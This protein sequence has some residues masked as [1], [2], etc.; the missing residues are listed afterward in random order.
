VADQEKLRLFTAIRIPSG[1]L[2]AIDAE[3]APHR[4]AF[5][6]ARWAPVENQ[7][8]TLKFLGSTPAPKVPDVKEAL[9]GVAAD[10]APGRI[11]LTS[12]GAF[13]TPRRARVLWIGVDDPAGLLTGLAYGL[14]R[15]LA[16]LGFKVEE[17]TYHPHLTLAR[18]KVPRALPE[19]LPDAAAGLAPF[20]VDEMVLFRSRLHPKGARYEVVEAFPLG[21]RA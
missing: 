15:A 13:P 6:G 10:L 7:H 12:L 11:A 8:L 21:S 19:Q 2:N 18:F 9:A 17:R 3:L 20:E 5:E 16:P 14:D 1:H 4:E